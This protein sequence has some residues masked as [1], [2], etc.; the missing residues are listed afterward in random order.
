VL[1]VTTGACALRH[2]LLSDETWTFT[3]AFTPEECR[4]RLADAL[5]GQLGVFRRKR[6]P[7]NAVGGSVTN[8]QFEVYQAGTMAPTTLPLFAWGRLDQTDV[9]TSVVVNTGASPSAVAMVAGSILLVVLW[10]SLAAIVA[11][12]SASGPPHWFVVAPVAVVALEVFLIRASATQRSESRR[13]MRSFLLGTLDGREQTDAETR[14]HA[15]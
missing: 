1:S 13:W 15:T 9:G 10:E 8:S 7:A 3:T 11:L 6:L 12:T 4:S 14:D 2:W 5:M